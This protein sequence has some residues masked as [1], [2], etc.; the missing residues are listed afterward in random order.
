LLYANDTGDADTG[1]N[2]KQNYPVLTSASSNTVTTTVAGSLNS[3]AS[4]Q[5]N[6]DF[7]YS[8]SCDASGKGE[9]KTYL[10]SGTATTDGTGNV[11]FNLVLN[12]ATPNAQ[13]VTGTATD[14]NGNTS[15]FSGCV[16]ST[17]TA[18]TTVTYNWHYTYDNLSRVTSACSAWTGSTCPAGKQFTYEY[19]GAGNL[20]RFDRFNKTTGT[21]ETVRYLYNGANQI[22]CVDADSSGTCNGSEFLWVYDAYGNLTNDGTTTYTYDDALR[23]KTVTVGGV[24]TT[25]EYNGDGVRTA[26][27]V[28]GVRT[29]YV[30]DVAASLPQV[31]AETTGGQTT[32]YLYALGLV[33]Q[34]RG[35]NNP[36]YFAYDGLGS[37]RQVLSNTGTV[38]EAQTYDP[39]GN[40]LAYSGP[41]PSVTG[42]GY[43]GEQHDQ[44]GL[45]YLRA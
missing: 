11:T 7:F 28:G 6:L 19:D 32:T 31:L 30:V 41:S 38:L 34:K 17:V 16:T 3:T 35:T 15:E 9:G 40:E 12:A 42:Y 27:I 21:I 33:G 10:G 36:E 18:P 25:Y 45:T 43:S 2:N 37:V 44:D 39:Y 13:A 24:T 29:D 8:P 1:A 5:Y 20:K 23:L 26:Q 4:T 14:P 22:K